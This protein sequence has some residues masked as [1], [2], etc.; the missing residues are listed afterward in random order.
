MEATPWDSL[1]LDLIGPCKIRG[2]GQDL[3][4]ILKYFTII[5]SVTGWFEIVH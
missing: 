4:L 2:I 1:F 5:Y 3:P